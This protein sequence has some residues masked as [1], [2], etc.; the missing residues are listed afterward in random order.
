MNTF[1]TGANGFIG[2]NLVKRLTSSGHSVKALV[3][4]GTSIENIKSTSCEIIYGNML[5]LS[6]FEDSLKGIDVIFHLAA[7]VSDWGR[8]KDFYKIN[9]S[10]TKHLINS[11]IKHK[12]KRFVFVSSL[13]IHKPRGYAK[14]DENAPRDNVKFSYA[15]SKI[16]IE[17]FLNECYSKGLIETTIIRPGVFPFGPEDRTSFYKIARAMEKGYFGYVK[18]GRA[19]LCTAYVENLVDGMVLA[20]EKEI[21]KG[22][23]YIIGDN[24]KITWRELIELFAKELKVNPPRLSI[25]YSV[26]KITANI[27]EILYKLLFIN[28]P[29]PLTDYRISLVAKDFYFTSEK[30]MNELGYKPSIPIHEGIRRTVEWYR[31]VE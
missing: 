8:W 23:A 17:D 26:A 11:A 10:A 29:P 16:M 15:L 12:V 19:L 9:V 24:V 13:A 6:Q 28:S 3:L 22:Q 5:N 4:P 1:V 21:A 30:A 7:R 2:S 27:M 20:G 25:P 31:G 18:G 14:G